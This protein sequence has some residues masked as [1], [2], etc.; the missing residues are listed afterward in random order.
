MDTFPPPK[1]ISPT[2]LNFE[3]LDCRDP[4][5]SLS[6]R[7]VNQ[8]LPEAGSGEMGNASKH[9]LM[10]N[11][12]APHLHCIF[13]P[14]HWHRSPDKVLSRSTTVAETGHSTQKKQK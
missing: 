6:M 9:R 7:S 5:A 4:A 11:V 13:F 14:L 12:L 1:P 2:G 10:V 8:M 3:L